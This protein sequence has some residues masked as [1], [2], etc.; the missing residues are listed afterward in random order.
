M[1]EPGADPLANARHE[2]FAQ[3][4]LIDRNGQA[5]YQ[6]AGYTAAGN[7]A[8]SAASRML[9]NVKV[10][11]R[12]AFLEAQRL[13]RVGMTADE[14]LRELAVIGSSDVRHYAFS[15]GGITLAEQ[16]P[17]VAMRAVQS[18]RRKVRTIDREDGQRETVEEVEFRLWSK[19][20]ALRM[21]GEHHRLFVPKVEVEQPEIRKTGEQV[22]ARIL[23]LL[24]RVIAFL[25][26]EK[27]ELMR[28]LER[29]R[30]RELLVSGRE[31]K[32]TKAGG[33]K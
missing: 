30:Q 2:R 9:R 21:A 14:V 26:V 4:Y 23:E 12:I 18:V 10:A 16:A 5:A 8:E 27:R 29:G 17:D 7:A 22:V 13:E 20:A 6:R 28:M 24:P 1:T 3:E 33:E 19:P 15:E 25:P 32:K 31:V 11:A